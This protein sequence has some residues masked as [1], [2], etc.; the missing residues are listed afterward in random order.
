[1]LKLT[2]IVLKTARSIFTNSPPSSGDMAA[3]SCRTI[4]LCSG[5]KMEMR[6]GRLDHLQISSS[7]EGARYAALDQQ[8]LGLINLQFVQGLL[9]LPH[10]LT[11]QG[12]LCLWP[13]QRESIYPW[14]VC[15][16]LDACLTLR[17][18]G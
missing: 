13:I 18:A 15:M 1:M 9:E 3:R 11:P 5:V 7:T 6:V 8:T 2:A 14:Q 16:G 12:V 4:F 10:Q 17:D